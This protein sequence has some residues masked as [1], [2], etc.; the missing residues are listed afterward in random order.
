MM[1]LKLNTFEDNVQCSDIDIIDALYEYSEA[2]EDLIESEH[3][4]FEI[5]RA[6]E[7]LDALKE[8]VI[9]HGW[10]E[11][12]SDLVGEQMS[13]ECIETSCE[14]AFDKIKQA[15]GKVGN[16][17]KQVLSKAFNVFDMYIKRFTAMKKWLKANKN[18]SSTESIYNDRTQSELATRDYEAHSKERFIKISDCLDSIRSQFGFKYAPTDG[19]DVSTL[20]SKMLKYIFSMSNSRPINLSTCTNSQL[21]D[22][23]DNVIRELPNLK[24]AIETFKDDAHAFRRSQKRTERKISTLQQ[25]K[26]SSLR[27]QAETDEKIDDYKGSLEITKSDRFMTVATRVIVHIAVMSCKK[28]DAEIRKRGYKSE[29]TV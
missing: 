24:K 14:G 17:V 25:S 12:L 15:A 11:T 10:S 19:V 8:I 27:E 18:G 22:L 1:D 7:N 16:A 4:L 5:N 23:C 2:Y 29:F 9:K 20:R 13:L 26:S 28:L 3:E 6:C 21:V